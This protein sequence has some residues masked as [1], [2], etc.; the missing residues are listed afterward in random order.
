[1]ILRRVV[2]ALLLG[3]MAATA[4]AAPPWPGFQII[5]WQPRTPAQLA[6]LRDLGVT[7]GMVMAARGG[8]VAALPA[9]AASLRAA[10]LGCYVENIATDFYSAYHRW[11]PGHAVNWR[12]VEAQQAYRADP[13]GMAP[14]IR[15][16]SLSDPVWLARI[17]D[18]L[19]A[20]VRAMRGLHPLFYDLGDETGIAD[21]TAFFDFDFSPASLDGMREWLQAGYG[22]LAALNA[23]WGTA[24]RVA[25]RAAGNHAPGDASRGRQLRAWADFKAWMDV[26]FARALRM[27]TDAVHSADPTA[28]AAIEGVQVP[29]GAAT[30]IRCSRRGR[31]DRAV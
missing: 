16:P 19:T 23:E 29:A 27:G 6:T 17:T 9:H 28:L 31:R 24:S 4:R 13:S 20:H 26:A 1:M 2:L 3:C 25:G 12:F 15:D 5:E 22:S 18:R 30:T 14:L 21:L 10:G 8:D 7:A 11:S